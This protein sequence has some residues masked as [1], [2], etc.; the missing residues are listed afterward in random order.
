MEKSIKK[1]TSESVSKLFLGWK[2]RIAFTA[3][4]LCLCLCVSSKTPEP[5]DLIRPVDSLQYRPST[6]NY[7]LDKKWFLSV[8]EILEGKRP[9]PTF[10]NMRRKI[11]VTVSNRYSD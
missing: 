4:L 5:S 10:T 6:K 9:T 11:D 8:T 3:T 7:P 2:F 1:S